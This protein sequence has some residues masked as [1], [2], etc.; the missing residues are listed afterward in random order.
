METKP[1]KIDWGESLE[2]CTERGILCH[3]L[4]EGEK[5]FHRMLLSSMRDHLDRIRKQWTTPSYR[6]QA[7]KANS[8]VDLGTSRA[9]ETG[10]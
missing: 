5:K 3:M 6:L 7:G 9:F 8:V 1:S 2:V 10:E 4:L